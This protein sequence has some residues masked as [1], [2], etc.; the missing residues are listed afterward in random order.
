MWRAK[1]PNGWGL[2][3]MHGNVWEWCQDWFGEYSSG[4]DIDPTGPESGNRRVLRGGS[5][6][7]NAR[8]VRSA[9]RADDDPGDRLILIGFRVARTYS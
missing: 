8:D 3:D 1:P 5:F 9:S 2:H 4:P 7:H 6:S